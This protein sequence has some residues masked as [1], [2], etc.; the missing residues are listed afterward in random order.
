LVGD[1]FS[2]RMCGD[3]K[4][5]DLPANTT[6]ILH[7]AN[8]SQ[9]LAGRLPMLYENIHR[10]NTV[11]MVAKECLPSLRQGSMVSFSSLVSISARLALP[12]IWRGGGLLP[13]RPWPM[14]SNPYSSRNEIVGTLRI[15][16]RGISQQASRSTISRRRL[17][18]R[19][20]AAGQ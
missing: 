1:P 12:N 3:A 16:A 2:R 4:P 14:I 8:G 5:E 15:G 9:C 17:P 20:P 13:R 7:D 19:K 6:E 10:G 18:S 11:G